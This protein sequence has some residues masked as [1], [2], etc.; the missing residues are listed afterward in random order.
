MLLAKRA[1][2]MF[3]I[4]PV[5]TSRLGEAGATLESNITSSQ[6][7]VREGEECGAPEAPNGKLYRSWGYNCGCGMTGAG[8]NPW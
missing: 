4:L 8:F 1:V 7:D 5:L 6:P 2:Q 3:E